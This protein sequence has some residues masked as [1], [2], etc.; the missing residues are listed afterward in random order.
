MQIKIVISA[1]TTSKSKKAKEKM[2]STRTNQYTKI[3]APSAAQTSLLQQ[4]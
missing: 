2:H 1:L 3:R 4:K